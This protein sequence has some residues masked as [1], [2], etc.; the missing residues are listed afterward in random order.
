MKSRPCC[1]LLALVWALPAAAQDDCVFL[2]DGTRV[3]AVRIDGYDVHSLRYSKGGSNTVAADQVAKVMLGRFGDVYRAG[4]EDAARMLTLAREQLAAR[5]TLL[6]QL[7]FLAAA[8]RWFDAGEPAKA[9]GVLEEVQK[10]IP[11]AG[12]LPADERAVVLNWIACG[13]PE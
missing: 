13:V 12:V 2:H 5:N 1:A 9:T 11:D 6:A 3:D 4:L 7:G 8:A 10:A